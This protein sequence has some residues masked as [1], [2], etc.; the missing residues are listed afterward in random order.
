MLDE[1]DQEC[2]DAGLTVETVLVRSRSAGSALI[3]EAISRG[4]D[5]LVLGASGGSRH[6]GDTEHVI[7]TV[8]ARA[9]RE[10]PCE[11][12]IVRTPP[13]ADPTPVRSPGGR[14]TAATASM[15]NDR[16]GGRG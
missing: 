7:G 12:W 11:V 8:A 3:D 2:E 10:A 14:P 1:A 13:T 6:Y 4:I 15:P 5:L 9:L 16:G